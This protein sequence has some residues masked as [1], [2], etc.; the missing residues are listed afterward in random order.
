MWV[1]AWPAHS[2]CLYLE[3]GLS[4]EFSGVWRESASMCFN[5]FILLTSVDARGIYL[6]VWLRPSFF[7]YMSEYSPHPSLPSGS[8]FSS[9]PPSSTRAHSLV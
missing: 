8:Y 5:R 4:L 2:E 9:H 1:Q 7:P 3:S 6:W